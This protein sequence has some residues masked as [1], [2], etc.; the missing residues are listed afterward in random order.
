M[1][2]IVHTN[3][4]VKAKAI[5]FVN[6]KCIE[7]GWIEGFYNG[8][9]TQCFIDGKL[10]DCPRIFDSS[11][12]LLQS[13]LVLPDTV[14]RWTD[15]YDVN[16][17]KIFENDITKLVLPNG[18]VRYF[19][20]SIKKIVRE[21]KNHPDFVGE[22]SKVMLNTVCFEWNGFSLLPCIDENGIVDCTKMEV[23]GNIFD[24]P[25]LLERAMNGN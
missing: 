9:A 11:F 24:N 2:T 6:H 8:Q 16:G 19:K 23:V 5:T 21:V 20:V 7:L 1:S 12:D 14:S 13:Y 22:Y 17:D 3:L 10:V 18:E 15:Y 25:D 4:E